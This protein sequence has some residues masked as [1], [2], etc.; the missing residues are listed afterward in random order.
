MRDLAFPATTNATALIHQFDQGDASSKLTVVF[1]TY[2]SLS[3]ISKAQGLGLPEFD[4]IICDEAHRTT[5]AAMAE[6]DRNPAHL[7]GRHT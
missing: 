7:L 2:Q 6:D 5:G 3:V 4:L 1:S